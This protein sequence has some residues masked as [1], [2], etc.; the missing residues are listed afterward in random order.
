MTHLIHPGVVHFAVA[1]LV[2]G[3]CAEAFGLIARRAAWSRFGAPWVVIGTVWLVPTLVTGFLAQNA[4]D[5]PAGAEGTL[6]L[7][8]RI[9]LA[10]FAVFAVALFWKAW[11]RGQLPDSHRLPYAVYLLAGVLLAAYGAFLGGELVYVHAVGVGIA[12]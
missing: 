3:G 9:G 10:L 4:V 1:F 11:V 7:H 8:E 2:V 6:A 5:V 12:R